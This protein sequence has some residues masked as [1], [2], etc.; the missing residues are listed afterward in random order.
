MGID[1]RGLRPA[2]LASGL[3]YSLLSQQFGGYGSENADEADFVYAA[4]PHRSPRSTISTQRCIAVAGSTVV[5]SR[6]GPRRLLRSASAV[7]SGT[8]PRRTSPGTNGS[9][10]SL[11]AG[12]APRLRKTSSPTEGWF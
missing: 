2:E 1:S 4:V 11:G 7:A 12:R 9:A 8:R 6:S 3:I 5:R 10:R